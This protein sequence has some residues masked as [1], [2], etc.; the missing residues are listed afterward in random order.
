MPA[1]YVNS[2]AEPGDN[3]G[4]ISSG[5][6]GERSVRKCEAIRGLIANANGVYTSP[7]CVA[8]EPGDRVGGVNRPAPVLELQPRLVIEPKWPEPVNERSC[9][10]KRRHGNEEFSSQAQRDLPVL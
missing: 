7:P 9:P 10:L 8:A 3:F 6:R 5:S 4:Y 1:D 2:S